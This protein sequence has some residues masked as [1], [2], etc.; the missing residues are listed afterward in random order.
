MMSIQGDVKIIDFGLAI[1]LHGGTKVEMCGSPYWLPPE[2][3]MRQP[4]SYPCDIWS[5]AVCILELAN[6]HPP[7]NDSALR[8]MFT[9]ATKKPPGLD[10]PDAWS[11]SFKDFLQCCLQ[12]DQTKR[13]TASELLK[14]RFMTKAATNPE[15]AKLLRSVFI[16]HQIREVAIA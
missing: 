8:H 12:Q 4:H 11:D 2:M 1:E 14:H 15:M 3:I 13:A 16:Q 6:R 7:N 5:M 9:V 10:K